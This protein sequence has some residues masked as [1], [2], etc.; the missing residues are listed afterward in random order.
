MS[1]YVAFTSYP[2][3][4]AELSLERLVLVYQDALSTTDKQ[5]LI[6]GLP[7]WAHQNHELELTPVVHYESHTS[8]VTEDLL[9]TELSKDLC[10]M[11]SPYRSLGPSTGLALINLS[12]P[13]AHKLGL[14]NQYIDLVKK[15]YLG[16]KPV[17]QGYNIDY[18]AAPLVRNRNRNKNKILK[19]F[20]NDWPPFNLNPDQTEL[21]TCWREYGQG[22]KYHTHKLV[23]YIGHYLNQ[24]HQTKSEEE[25]NLILNETFED[26]TNINCDPDLLVLVT[27]VLL[28]RY[29][30]HTPNLD[31]ISILLNKIQNKVNIESN[32]P[33]DEFMRPPV[34]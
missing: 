25:Y 12:L 18:L 19:R 23:H 9:W 8:K 20:I 34:A 21:E 6:T 10:N 26:L 14:V 27:K 28:T 5:E 1:V 7:A 33:Y 29:N 16:V 17:L 4:P 31:S 11:T 30:I 2:K 3:T 13:K 32:D 22:S 24:C 15:N